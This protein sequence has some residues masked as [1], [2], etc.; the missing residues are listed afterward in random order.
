MAIKSAPWKDF[1]IYIDEKN[2]VKVFKSG[3]ICE[4]TKAA[5]REI[6][7]DAGFEIEKKWN[8][9][10]CGVKM[11]KFLLEASS[12]DVGKPEESQIKDSDVKVDDGKKEETRKNPVED[13]PKPVV[14]HLH[15]DVVE[16]PF[17]KGDI[18]HDTDYPE[19]AIEKL[20]NLTNQLPG[21]IHIIASDVQGKPYE[22]Y[23]TEMTGTYLHFQT[24]RRES[25]GLK[26]QHNPTA[27]TSYKDYGY[28]SNSGIVEAP[29]AI[30]VKGKKKK[31]VAKKDTLV[32]KAILYGTVETQSCPQTE[33][34][35]DCAGNGKC[36]SCKGKGITDCNDCGG[37]GRCRECSGRGKIECPDCNGSAICPHCHGSGQ[38]TECPECK[39][40]GKVEEKGLLGI[41]TVK[42]KRCDGT[43]QGKSYYRCDYCLGTKK[44]SACNGRGRVVCPACDGDKICRKCNGTKKVSC[45]VCNGGKS[46]VRCD[47]NGV[48][49]CQRCTGT[50]KYQ[51]YSI[52][53]IT[54]LTQKSKYLDS[55][56][57]GIRKLLS[58]DVVSCNAKDIVCSWEHKNND[59]RDSVANNT[60]LYSAVLLDAL[61]GLCVSGA[62]DISKA[63]TSELVDDER[64]YSVE[65]D[66]FSK[67]L[68]VKTYG[69]PISSYK[70]TF[71][72]KEY[73]FILA[74]RN[75]TSI[76]GDHPNKHFFE[77]VS[78]ES[79]GFFSSLKKNVTG[80]LKSDSS[81]RSDT[82]KALVL[83][84]MRIA[85]QK[86]NV[87][88]DSLLNDFCLES[89]F[90][91]R[92]S[93]QR[94]REAVNKEMTDK[95]FYKEISC[96]NGIAAA[97]VWAYIFADGDSVYKDYAS[98]LG[99]ND[100]DFFNKVETYYKSNPWKKIG[101]KEL[102]TIF[103]KKFINPV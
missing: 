84:S 30:T 23:I 6:A 28:W 92:K 48:V 45:E 15:N 44:C 70:F 56:L 57:K 69:F 89:Q 21:A 37:N 100:K 67:E 59:Y 73:S 85:K 42:C 63:I 10:Q 88:V 16:F 68:L 27:A 94:I 33:T 71:E 83:L 58:A 20:N 91:D 75:S 32:E 14:K 55:N 43:G 66:A 24:E 31:E 96:L 99:I 54:S 65:K 40:T 102:L 51:T 61:R 36:R 78:F 90:E 60:S 74:G 9:Q 13:K 11:V 2:S 38:Q 87:P 35:P 39:G 97:A 7:Q 95:D 82:I 8:T 17:R 41:R 98:Q 5:L 1:L 47:G 93:A 18:L 103:S 76:I 34:C 64:S 52:L 25:P 86:G 62:E 19:K 22:G 3:N 81:Q 72:E 29:V 79:K 50:G 101:P 80:L 12:S 4:N 53:N 49:S 46:C 77:G 26:Y